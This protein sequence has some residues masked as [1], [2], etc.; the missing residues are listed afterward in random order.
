MFFYKVTVATS[1]E[2]VLARHVCLNDELA[3]TDI[4]GLRKMLRL[5]RYASDSTW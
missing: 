3:L 1:T 2:K 4:G 5:G